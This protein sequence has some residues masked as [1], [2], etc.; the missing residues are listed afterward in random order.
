MEELKQ[1]V[2]LLKDTP[3][4]VIWLVALYFFYKLAIV[5][6]VFKLLYVGIKTT[7]RVIRPDPVD[8]IELLEKEMLRERQTSNVKRI[9]KILLDQEAIHE[10]AALLSDIKEDNKE[11]GGYLSSYD[12]KQIRRKL[13]QDNV[14]DA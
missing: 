7:A 5:G 11:Y 6:S 14:K 4:M 10:M 12:I 9:A 8:Q 1:L 3:N 2:E 13:K